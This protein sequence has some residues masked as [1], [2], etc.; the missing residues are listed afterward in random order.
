M[1]TPIAVGLLVACALASCASE[2]V[3]SS[4][5]DCEADVLGAADAAIEF[6][7]VFTAR[8]DQRVLAARG[9]RRRRF[10]RG[11]L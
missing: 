8:S 10:E 2:D 7:R 3:A 11:F 6:T 5:V 9:A 1:T 4:S